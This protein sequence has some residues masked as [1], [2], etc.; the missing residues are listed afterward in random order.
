M[1]KTFLFLFVFKFKKH[2][3]LNL[4]LART[5][6]W[7]L[8]VLNQKLLGIHNLSKF[9]IFSFTNW[10]FA[11]LFLPGCLLCPLLFLLKFFLINV[12]FLQ[13]WERWSYKRQHTSNIKNHHE[14]FAPNTV[15]TLNYLQSY[16]FCFIKNI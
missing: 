9:L 13:G 11:L 12:F 16:P 6:N 14:L 2:W 15:L 4:D 5:S 7:L 1:L 8:H 3:E 10:A